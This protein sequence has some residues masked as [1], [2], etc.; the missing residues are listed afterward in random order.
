MSST[1][2]KS[3]SSPCPKIPLLVG[4][5]SVPVTAE[6]GITHSNRTPVVPLSGSSAI[7]VGFASTSPLD[8][9]LNFPPGWQS[10]LSR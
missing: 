5:T 2:V 4:L 1:C 9:K 6:F 7:P 8:W 10:P 3:P